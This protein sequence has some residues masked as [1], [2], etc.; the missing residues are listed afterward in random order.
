MRET[1]WNVRHR[2]HPPPLPG[3]AH[4][5]RPDRGWPQLNVVRVAGYAS[6]TERSA[7]DAG[8]GDEGDVWIDPAPDAPPNLY[9]AQLEA[10][11]G[12]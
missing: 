8:P 7:G 10:R 2:G 1:L 12:R 9:E 4:F 11:L 6:S 5:D 3:A